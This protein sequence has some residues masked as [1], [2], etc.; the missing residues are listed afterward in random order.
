MGFSGVRIVENSARVLILGFGYWN[1]HLL[2]FHSCHHV[3]FSFVG[4]TM[5]D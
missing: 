3:L 5:A 4:L 2:F 1:I